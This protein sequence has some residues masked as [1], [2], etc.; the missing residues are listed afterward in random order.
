MGQTDR[1]RAC[2]QM[3]PAW[4]HRTVKPSLALLCFFCRRSSERCWPYVQQTDDYECR[5]A[6]TL[7][8]IYLDVQCIWVH[9]QHSLYTCQYR[10]IGYTCGLAGW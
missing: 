7:E 2:H 6:V 10:F 9:V 4:P 8:G 5:L 1:H 3:L